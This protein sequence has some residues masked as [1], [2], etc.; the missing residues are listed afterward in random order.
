MVEVNKSVVDP[1]LNK[2]SSTG[3][4]AKVAI[5]LA[6]IFSWIGGLVFYLIEKENRAVKWNALQA[7]IIGICDVIILIV[8]FGFLSW[9][10]FIGILFMVLGW[11]A[12]VASLAFKI[13]AI[14]QAFQGK[15]YRIPG[16]SKLTDKYIKY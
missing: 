12:L 4:D 6:Y 13:I 1:D 9:I 3:M 8:F 7:L 15:T 11:L 2:K 5:L 10:P 16:I 14:V